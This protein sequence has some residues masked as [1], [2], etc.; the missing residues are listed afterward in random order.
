M[1]SEFKLKWKNIVRPQ[2]YVTENSRWYRDSSINKNLGGSGQHATSTEPIKSTVSL[3]ANG[4]NPV[5]LSNSSKTFIYIENTGSAKI[6]ISLHGNNSNS[7]RIKIDAGD[8]YVS[9]IRSGGG[10]IYAKTGENVAGTCTVVTG[11]G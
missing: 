4:A 10:A 8:C 6:L 1:A 2:E 9:K 11:V 7:Y 5:V 3:D